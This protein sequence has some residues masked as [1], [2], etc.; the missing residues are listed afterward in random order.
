[1]LLLAEEEW[2]VTQA[3]GLAGI[4]SFPI[5]LELAGFGKLRVKVVP[6]DICAASSTMHAT[7]WM[8][9]PIS[10]SH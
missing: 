8:M 9:R 2:R 3:S 1:M 5:G 6:P 4:A 7:A 10:C